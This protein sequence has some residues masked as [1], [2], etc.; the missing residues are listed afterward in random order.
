MHVYFL[1]KP[2]YVLLPSLCYCIFSIV[3]LLLSAC[4]SS[5]TREFALNIE[6]AS[7]TAQKPLYITGKKPITQVTDPDGL[8]L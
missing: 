6:S 5:R 3:F 4:G 7:D 2:H 1:R 8:L